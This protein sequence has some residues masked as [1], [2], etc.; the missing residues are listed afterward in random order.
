LDINCIEKLKSEATKELK[1]NI[2]AFW[3]NNTLDLENGGIY[4]MV[5]NSNEVEKEAPK[6]CI[7]NSRVLWTFS[8]AYRVFKDENYLRV[9]KI[10]YDFLVRY[11]YDKEYKGLYWMVDYKGNPINTR[12][13]IYNIAFGIY[14]LSEYYRATGS[15][16]ALDYAI[17]LYQVIEKYSYDSVNKG[18][19]EA[20][21]RDWS[22]V[23]D[24]RLSEKEPN[25]SKTMNTHLHILEAYTNLYRVWKD[26]SFKAKFK[27][28][29]NV[30]MDHIIDHDRFQF[31]L[32]FNDDWNSLEDVI[33]FGHDIEG[34]WLLYEA[35]SVLGDEDILERAKEFSIKMAEKVYQDGIDRVHGGLYNEI[36]EEKLDNHKAWWPQ[37]ETMVGFLNSYELTGEEKF[38]D[39][40]YKM[41]EYIQ[42]VFVV[43][44]YGEWYSSVSL[45]GKPNEDIPKVEPWKCPYHNGRSCFEIIERLNKKKI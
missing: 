17:E 11:F 45:E 39:E 5:S 18:Y 15:K 29:I 41:W 42:R 1:G 38:L 43:K 34:S 8:N 36:K 2:L 22:K 13:Q 27:E 33:S 3:M 12:K 32:F 4:G 16:E 37:A 24:L 35:A 20:L 10:A 21:E 14:G 30:T 26:D 31:K 40:T 44:K 9:A 6:G 19:I 7:L 25:C 23:K 28:L